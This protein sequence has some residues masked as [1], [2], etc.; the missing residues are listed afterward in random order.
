MVAFYHTNTNYLVTTDRFDILLQ[1]PDRNKT[2]FLPPN[3]WNFLTVKDVVNDRYFVSD[4]SGILHGF[5]TQG[6]PY[7][8]SPFYIGPYFLQFKSNGRT[9][10]NFLFYNKFF[11]PNSYS[12][13]L[14]LLHYDDNIDKFMSGFTTPITVQNNNFLSLNNLLE[15][16]I[17]D[18]NQNQVEFLDNSQLFIAIEIQN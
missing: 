13:I 12:T 8:K 6:Y 11:T 5:L 17:V 7:T 18:S 2:F 15:F 14:A 1:I 10:S 4:L 16:T 3:E 9:E